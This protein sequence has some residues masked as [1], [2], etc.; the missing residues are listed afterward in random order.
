VSF[1]RT[2]FLAAF[3]AAFA[4]VGAAT[5]LVSWSVRRDL[6]A[7]L[8]RSLVAEAQLAAALLARPMAV[9]ENTLDEEADEIGR[10]IASRVTLIAADGRVSGD[11]ELDGAELAAMENHGTRPEVLGALRSGTGISTRHS[12]TIQTDMLY[13]AVPVRGGSNAVAVVRLALPLIEVDEQLGTVRRLA[14]LALGVGIVTAAAL[15]WWMS[16]LVSRRVT[17][18]AA[19]ARRYADGDYSRA[20]AEYGS[21]EIG[22]VAKVLDQSVQDLSVRLREL[23]R[24]R[25]LMAGILGGM[26]E[27]VIVVNARGQLQLVN[28]AARRMVGL[29]NRAA[30]GHYLETVRHPGIAQQIGRAVAGEA[31]PPVE[32]ALTSHDERVFIAR[33][34]AVDAPGGP[35]AV[36]VLHDISDLKRADRVRRDFVANVS[37]ELRTPLTAIRGYVEALTDGTDDREQERRFLEVIARQTTRMERLVR[38]LLRL[39]RIEGGQEQIERNEISVNTLFA[40][41]EGALAPMLQERQQ[42]VNWE[43]G[44][45]AETI[46]ADAAKMHDVIRNLVE[47]ASNYSDAGT[48]IRLRATHVE[49]HIVI[50]VEDEGPGIPEPELARVFERFYRVDKARA[51][52]R[53]QGGTGLGLAIVKHLV[54]LHGGT[55]TA[56]NRED[57]GAIFAVSLPIEN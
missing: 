43:I 24:D 19:T 18:I 17:S 57:G 3:A 15:A 44:S 55:I 16:A 6:V 37:H 23:A 8:E 49:E 31:P 13:V 9:D 30:G 1:R 7:R 32:V 52:T 26:S 39:A 21:D 27:G 5:A 50:E 38:D 4:T 28:E 47:N 12:A 40:D 20:P 14:L 29:E 48:T 41:V 11:S 10:R 51:R 22:T 25:A 42:T 2:L 56:R 36:V 35:L 53:E 46:R 54:G 33:A 45:R 34:T